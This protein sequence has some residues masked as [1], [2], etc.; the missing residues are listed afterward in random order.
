MRSR[1]RPGIRLRYR[2][3]SRMIWVAVI[4]L[5]SLGV[6][7]AVTDPPE[8]HDAED[9]AATGW[10]P[11]RVSAVSW[12]MATVGG[13]AVFAGLAVTTGAR[14]APVAALAVAAWVPVLLPPR[15]R[16]MILRAHHRHQAG[17]LH[18]WL[19]R[20]R[21]Y[22]AV[23]L[24][25]RDAVVRAA[26]QTTER[27]FTPVASAIA[28]ALEGGRDPLTAAA[29]RV[30]GSA[31]ETLL[32]T[33]DTVERTGTAATRLIDHVIDR[34]VAVY[35][36]AVT[37]RTDRLGRTTGTLGTIVVAFSVMVLML[38]VA[39]SINNGITP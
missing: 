5:V 23:G 27:A 1:V 28:V 4:S 39:V 7:L 13:M 6:V 8:Y 15:L 11:S 20:V 35:S 19:R 9:L 16:Q 32:G 36:A 10:T 17:A 38:G 26:H 33:V 3:D 2:G 30:R 34:A 31:A 29:L 22:T 37:E 24:P 18:S 12:G 25:M 14:S 21:L